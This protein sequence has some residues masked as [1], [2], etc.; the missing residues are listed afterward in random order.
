MTLPTRDKD[1]ELVNILSFKRVKSPHASSLSLISSL[2][3]F[4]CCGID[5]EIANSLPS[6]SNILIALSSPKRRSSAR[7]SS[8]NIGI[9]RCSMLDH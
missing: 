3:F 2:A 5:C 9:V 1:G 8:D 6:F 4:A 7:I